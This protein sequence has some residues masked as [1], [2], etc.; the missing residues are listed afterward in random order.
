LRLR[1]PIFEF[2]VADDLAAG[3]L[4]RPLE[5]HAELVVC[6]EDPLDVG[7]TPRSA[8]GGRLRLSA[9]AGVRDDGRQDHATSE[10]E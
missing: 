7:I 2:L 4:L 5:G 1:L 9:D 3:E 10:R 6:R 8:E